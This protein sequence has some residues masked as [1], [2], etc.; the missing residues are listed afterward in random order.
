MYAWCG[1]E[2]A[3]PKG[4]CGKASRADRREETACECEFDKCGCSKKKAAA[5][6][7]ENKKGDDEEESK[8]ENVE[9]TSKPEEPTDIEQSEA[10]DSEMHEDNE[11]EEEKESIFSPFGDIPLSIGEHIELSL[12][13]TD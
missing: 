10:D 9:E 2:E 4:F 12:N 13:P 6:A 5:S 1:G 8:A 3:K 11:E 7:S